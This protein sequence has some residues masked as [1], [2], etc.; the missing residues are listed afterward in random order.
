MTSFTIC[1]CFFDNTPTKHHLCGFRI[2]YFFVSVFKSFFHRLC[3][4]FFKKLIDE[5]KKYINK[6]TRA[7]KKT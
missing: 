1:F 3:N 5:L 4:F 7:K 2:S 6:K